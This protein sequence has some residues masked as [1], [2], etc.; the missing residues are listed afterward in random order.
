MS[1]CPNSTFA[2]PPATPSPIRPT[3]FSRATPTAAPTADRSNP[4]Y[5]WCFVKGIDVKADGKAAAIVTFGDSITDGA[6]GTRDANGRWPDVLAA[7]LQAD[8][9]TADLGV[10]NEGIGGNRVLHDGYAR[11][12]WHDSTAT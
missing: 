5:A 1:T 2:T 10:L 9:K 7:R 4:I 12:R 8:K 6:Q 11:A 3:T